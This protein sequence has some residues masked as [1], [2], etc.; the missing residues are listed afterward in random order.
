MKFYTDFPEN[1]EI[2]CC[3]KHVGNIWINIATDQGIQMFYHYNSN[4]EWED[5]HCPPVTLTN[6]SSG[7][8]HLMYK[9][10]IQNEQHLY[11]YPPEIIQQTNDILNTISKYNITKILLVIQLSKLCL[12]Q[13]C[14]FLIARFLAK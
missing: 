3:E 11:P 8:L 14:W 4:Y 1:S 7:L 5:Y 6:K 2:Q 9:N 12:T 10:F 13:D